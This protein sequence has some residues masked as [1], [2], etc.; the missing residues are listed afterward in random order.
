MFAFL[1]STVGKYLII[2]MVLLAVVGGAYF[3]IKSTTA[4]ITAL[5]ERIVAL[6]I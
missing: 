2:A 5:N 3:Y 6:A 4:E 1:G